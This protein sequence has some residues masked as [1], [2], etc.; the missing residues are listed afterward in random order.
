MALMKGSSNLVGLDIGTTGIRVV[1]VRTGREPRLITYGA[2]PIDAKVSQSDAD[3]DRQQVASAVLKLLSDSRATTRNVVVGLSTSRVFTSVISLPK[4]GPGE[5]AK[6]VQY[7]GEQHVPMSLEQVKLDWMIAGEAADSNQQEVLLVAAPNNLTERYLSMLEAIGLEV[8]AIE[9]DALA[10]NRALVNPQ[11]GIVM[12]L[13][14][15]AKSADLVISQNGLPKLIRSVPIGGDSFIKAASQNL[16]LEPDQAFQFVYKFGLTASKMEGQV[17]KAIKNSVDSLVS[18]VDKSVKFFINRY[19]GM[20]VGKIILCGKAAMLPDF[21]GYLAN[22][23]VLPVEIGNAWGH[24]ATP[25]DLQ[26]QLMELSNQ[27]TVACGL[28]LRGFEP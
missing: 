28:A 14:V 9:P 13:D 2:V 21:P 27:F 26:T 5:L 8:M 20:Q 18:D 25:V 10:I 7:Q 15:G 24:I 19:K 4:M 23:L 22:S 16:N 17:R 12:L 1:E 6:A 11:D 3:I